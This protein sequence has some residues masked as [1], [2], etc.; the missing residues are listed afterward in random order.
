MGAKSIQGWHSIH[1]HRGGEALDFIPLPWKAS[2]TAGLPPDSP[3]FPSSPTLL[4]HQ[5][6]LW[7]SLPR[8]SLNTG[9]IF[10]LWSDCFPF[11]WNNGFELLAIKVYIIFSCDLLLILNPFLNPLS[12]LSTWFAWSC[13]STKSWKVLVLWPVH[14]ASGPWICSGSNPFFILCISGLAHD[15]P[16][17]VPHFLPQK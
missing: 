13:F 12:C 8:L 16:D 6:T 10:L 4:P 1:R 5:L 17:L 11:F 7:L 15:E 3:Y 14:V 2:S 9:S